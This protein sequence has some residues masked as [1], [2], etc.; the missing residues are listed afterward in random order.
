MRVG[1]AD[2]ERVPQ[3]PEKRGIVD[4]AGLVMLEMSVDDKARRDLL[5]RAAGM[6]GPD[7]HHL[8]E[9]DIEH[10]TAEIEQQRVG[11]TGEKRGIHPPRLQNR[12]RSGNGR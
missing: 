9:I 8:A 11:G 2:A 4:V 10:D 1:Y 12:A 3:I 7:R 5:G 6:P